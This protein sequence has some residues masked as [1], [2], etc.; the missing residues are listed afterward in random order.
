LI[1]I[2][3]A[4]GVVVYAYVIGFVGNSTGNQG[5]S[6]NL[7][8]I[9][10]F[11]A[12]SKASAFPATAYVRNQ[13]PSSEGFNNGF[14]ITGSNVNFQLAPAVSLV[15]ASGS[16]SVTNVA[17]SAAGTNVLTVTLTCTSTGTATVT[18]F[19]VSAT[20]SGCSGTSATATLTLPVG[21]VLSSTIATANTAFASAALSATPIIVG[22][23][24]TAGTITVPI[25]TVLQFNLSPQ[26][27]LVASGAGAGQANQPLSAGQTYII[28]VTGTD[29]SSTTSSSKSS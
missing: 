7:I 4:A 13:G 5:G 24:L 6:T 20:S 17:L 29:G 3:I 28:H 12:N 14:F 22:V 15:L 11:N 27:E 8:S 10:Q 9:D 25:N 1:L 26:G 16:I 19:G 2:A 21:I 18:A 23:T